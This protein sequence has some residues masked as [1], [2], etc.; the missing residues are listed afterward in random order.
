MLKREWVM[1]L[2]DREYMRP[3][4]ARR[5]R[6]GLAL[7]LRFALWR[8]ARWLRQTCCKSEDGPV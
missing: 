7:R 4:P 1:G 8:M 5:R 6:I 2:M 3:D